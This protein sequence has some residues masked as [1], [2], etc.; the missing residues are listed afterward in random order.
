MTE[1]APILQPAGPQDAEVPEELREVF[2][3]AA[4]V[5]AAAG[6]APGSA[7]LGFVAGGMEAIAWVWNTVIPDSWKAEGVIAWPVYADPALRETQRLYDVSMQAV[8]A[9]WDDL[10]R[11][12][13]LPQDKQRAAA[14]LASAA[15]ARGWEKY[16]YHAPGGGYVIGT[17]SMYAERY[18][19]IYGAY[20]ATVMQISSFGWP[21]VPSDTSQAD[22][23]SFVQTAKELINKVRIQPLLE[24]MDETLSW[25]VQQSADYQRTAYQY[26][27]RWCTKC[28]GL[29]FASNSRGACPSGGSH[30]L[31]GSGNYGLVN[32]Q[33]SATGQPDWRWPDY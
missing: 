22:V 2:A 17:G 6:F 4:G 23:D 14:Y 24:S 13:K 25:I 21:K 28:Q 5:F 27:W 31:Q 1:Y 15:R 16:A 11:R 3:V 20:P 7:A 29:F 8:E 10:H 33:A 32:N 9:A 12:G 18:L 30:N 19:R 26:G